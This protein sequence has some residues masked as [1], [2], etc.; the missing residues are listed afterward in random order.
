MG[1]SQDAS[2]VA[3]EEYIER[4]LGQDAYFKLDTATPATS[5]E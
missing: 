2:E 5:T 1:L 3:D 4:V